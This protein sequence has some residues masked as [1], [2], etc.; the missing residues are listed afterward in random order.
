[1]RSKSG[2]YRHRLFFGEINHASISTIQTESDKPWTIFHCPDVVS[3]E[4]QI[5]TFHVSSIP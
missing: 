5:D 1:M 2:Y 4:F 3:C